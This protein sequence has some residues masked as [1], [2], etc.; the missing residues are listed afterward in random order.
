MDF[1]QGL[2]TTIHEYGISSD[3]LKELNNKLKNKATAILIPCLYEEFER[4]ALK[5]IR[6]VLRQLN[7]LNELVI[8]LSAKSQ[9]QVDQA[10]SFFSSMPFPVHL[11]WTN[12]P[13]VIELLKSQEKN[14]LELLG[15]PGKGWAVWQGI[16]VATRKSEVVALFDADIRTFNP[17]YPSRMILP[18]LDESYGIS[19]VKAFY[20][21]LSL[22]TNALQG[23]A[24]RLFVGP[25]LASLEQLVGNGPFL[26]YLESF[27]YPLAGEFAFT[28][29]LAMNLRIPCDWGLEIGLLSEVY[30]NVRTSKIAQVDLGLFDHKH[31]T[32]GNTSKEGLQ[33]MCTEILS[34]VLRGLMEHQ[35]ETLTNTQLSTLEVLYKRVG[36]DRVKQFG[37]DSAVNQ[38][39]Y[40]RH[41]EELSVQKFAKLLRPATEN[42]LKSPATQQLPSWSR[43]LSCEHRLQEDLATSG[44]TDTNLI[45]NNEELINNL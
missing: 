9:D 13:L 4:P 3:L 34:S 44:S 22:E 33:R 24:T 12:S 27:R 17:S 6:E 16:G 30:R 37:L 5:N 23:R 45:R 11:Q 2:I 20:S 41:E 8:A 19:Y 29:D 38:I 7:G 25:L 15:T 43:V 1:Q 14:G 18:L 35:A 40:D 32:I 42:F 10:R 28:K 39:P 26:K 21:R 31:K 36:E